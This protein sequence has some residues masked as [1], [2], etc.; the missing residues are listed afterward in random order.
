MYTNECN[1]NVIDSR[2]SAVTKCQNGRIATA[3][4]LFSTIFQALCLGFMLSC[5]TCTEILCCI[6][7]GYYN[8][9]ENVHYTQGLRTFLFL[10]MVL[11]RSSLLGRTYL[12]C[13]HCTQTV[14][15]T[16]ALSFKH[17]SLNIVFSN[18]L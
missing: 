1:L 18:V 10:Q 6:L 3:S 8:L 9:I 4:P 14:L 16:K 15:Y 13:Y 5:I 2:D 17:L 7:C 12:Q 11:V